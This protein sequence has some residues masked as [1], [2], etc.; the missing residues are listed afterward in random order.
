MHRPFGRVQSD[1]TNMRAQV[2]SKRSVSGKFERDLRLVFHP[3]RN[4][5]LSVAKSGITIKFKDKD[6]ILEKYVDAIINHFGIE[7]L[8]T[9]IVNV[10]V[11]S[12][13]S[14]DAPIDD[15]AEKLST[16]TTSFGKLKLGHKNGRTHLTWRVGPDIK[17]QRD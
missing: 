15:L 7:P 13:L 10:N 11:S 8:T 12:L 6:G 3:R 9:D 16:L 4:V 5:K 2:M 17:L 14:P 1:K